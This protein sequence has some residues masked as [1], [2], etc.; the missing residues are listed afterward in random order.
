MSEGEDDEDNGGGHCES[1][2]ALTE[3]PN[4]RPRVEAEANSALAAFMDKFKQPAPAENAKKVRKVP[5]EKA[6]G[7]RGSKKKNGSRKSDVKH[8]TLLQ[9]PGEFP[10][11][12]FKVLNGQL[13][14]EA[15]HRNVGSAMQRCRDHIET[16]SH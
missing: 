1:D 13:Y 7:K 11:Q 9:R 5:T 16:E 3:R 12:G 14:C 2:G 8:C 10:G 6:R 4:K 15:C